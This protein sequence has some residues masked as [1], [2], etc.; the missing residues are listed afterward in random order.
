MAAHYPI[1]AHERRVEQAVKK[2]AEHIHS[3]VSLHFKQSTVEASIKT[4]IACLRVTYR[5]YES[6]RKY[7]KHLR[8]TDECG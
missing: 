8:N 7:V 6:R 1:F 3:A 2:A 5:S 4:E